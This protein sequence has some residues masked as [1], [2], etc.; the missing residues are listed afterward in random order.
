MRTTT[1]RSRGLLALAGAI[2]FLAV[3]ATVFAVHDDNLFELGEPPYNAG[4]AII[5]GDGN[6]ATGRDWGALF[7][8]TGRVKGVSAVAGCA[9]YNDYGGIGADFVKDDA[10]SRS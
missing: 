2:F 5:G 1:F 7:I 8:A 6:P 10:A 3:A 9:D 4:G